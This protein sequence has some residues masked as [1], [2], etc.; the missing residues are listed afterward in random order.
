MKSLTRRQIGM[1]LSLGWVLLLAFLNL[2]QADSV[3]AGTDWMFSYNTRRLFRNFTLIG[4]SIGVFLLVLL[5]YGSVKYLKSGDFTKLQPGR[6]DAVKVEIPVMIAAA[7]IFFAFQGGYITGYYPFAVLFGEEYIPYTVYSV[8][9][10]MFSQAVWYGILYAA[11]L[12]LVRRYLLHSIRE[13]SWIAGRIRAY[14]HRTEPEKRLDN[15]HKRYL[16]LMAVI[17]VA[18]LITLFLGYTRN[19]HYLI[20]SGALTVAAGVVFLFTYLSGQLRTDL[21]KLLHQIDDMAGGEKTAAEKLLPETSVLY[22]ASGQLSH[23]EAAMEN[24]IARQVQA[25]R[26]KIDLVTNVSHDLKTP[27]TSMVGYTDLLKLEPLSAEAQDY[28]EVIALKQE[29]LKDM[30]QDLFE[31]AKSTSNSEQLQIET[32]D[33]KKLLEQIMADMQDAIDTSECEFRSAFGEE[34]LLFL[35]DNRKMYRVVQ[36]LL[37]NALKYALSGTRIYVTAGRTNER[38]VMTIKNIAA[39][40]MNFTAEEITERFARGDQSRS[41]EGHGLGLA[42]ASSFTRNMG[43]SMEVSVDG[44]LFKVTLEF[45]EDTTRE[46]ST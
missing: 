10:F 20:F 27:L 30:I 36:N 12:L 16:I 31:L 37:E 8:I 32:L 25:E 4:G 34:P 35:G 1:A 33:M 9:K 45:P 38:I 17:L 44:D 39:Y 24:T 13:T 19:V 22:Q 29:Q 40:E 2:V 23:I 41:T 11:L 6:L 5:L 15:R 46:S 28:V 18:D 26:M 42:I 3:Y 7:A 43:G 21:G 14:R